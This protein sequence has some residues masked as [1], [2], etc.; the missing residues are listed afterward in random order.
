M[1]VAAKFRRGL[2]EDQRDHWQTVHRSQFTV[3]GQPFLETAKPE[4]LQTSQ[5]ECSGSSKS[6]LPN[7]IRTIR[8]DHKGHKDRRFFTEGFDLSSAER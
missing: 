4:L 1:I 5:G 7:S 3:R 6:L 8:K 2:I